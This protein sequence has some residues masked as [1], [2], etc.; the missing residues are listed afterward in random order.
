MQRKTRSEIDELT[1]RCLA[2]FVEAGSLD[3]SL[4]HL[5]SKVG[6]SKRMLIHYFG[7]RENLEEG[8]FALLED[9]LR[10][11]FRAELFSPGSSPKTVVG[12]LWDQITAPASRGTLLVVMD[13][14]RR[15]WSGTERAKAFYAE[16]QRLWV[17]LLGKFL[18]D[19]AAVEELLQLF[20]GA[21]LAYLVTGDRE[22][23]K[24][25]LVRMILKEQADA[26]PS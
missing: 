20:Q 9:R 8:A 19:P 4:D 5:S 22:M 25:A 10:A 18:P 17:E 1:G 16:Q 12:A 2:A 11:T 14:T 3:L 24:R 21:V 7:S 6:V 26:A 23:G 15:A 13:A